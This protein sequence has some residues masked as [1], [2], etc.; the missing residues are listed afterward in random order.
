MEGCLD[1]FPK[2]V[3][4][5]ESVTMSRATSQRG[6]EFK[7]NFIAGFLAQNRLSVQCHCSGVKVKSSLPP[8][9][10]LGDVDFFVKIKAGMSATPLLN[11]MPSPVALQD[12]GFQLEENDN[13][14]FE[15]TTQEGENVHRPNSKGISFIQ[16]KITFHG[17]IQSLAS[18]FMYPGGCGSGGRQVLILVYNGADSHQVRPA[19]NSAMS[20]YASTMTGTSVFAS[21]STVASWEA[22]TAREAADAARVASERRAAELETARDAS[23]RRA[24]ELETARVA[25]E[26][27]A[28]E[29]ETA[30]DAS[31]RRAAELEAEL[32]RLRQQSET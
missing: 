27:R 10:L 25:S 1:H 9:E 31:E 18:D 17:K 6:T 4:T 32:A 11:F 23:E 5:N 13:V 28:A 12:R 7:E 20:S 19:L 15:L 2:D 21:S 26:R 8:N 24:A 22:N 30:R 29:L 16:K 14:F 3:A